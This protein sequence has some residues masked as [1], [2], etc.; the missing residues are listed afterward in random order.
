MIRVG[1]IGES[2]NDTMP[3]CEI[4]NREFGDKA[5]FKALLK[6]LTGGTLDS[7]PAASKRIKAELKSSVGKNKYD[8]LI[9]V[10][11][12]DG[13]ESE[14]NKVDNVNVWYNKL[15]VLISNHV[16][17]LNIHT[18]EALV[19]ADI[20]VFNKSYGTK[21][22]FKGDPQ[23][24]EKP[25]EFLKEKSRKT[26]RK[27]RERDIGELLPKLDFS[28]MKSKCSSFNKFIDELTEKLD[29]IIETSK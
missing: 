10:R 19:L 24:K 1:I 16:L 4:L 15:S 26:N 29:E 2:P 20:E 7:I 23:K 11:D 5:S 17:L 12:L 21:I 6:R 28:K 18:V 8:L 13:F 25:K 9:F 3:V 22:S 27:Y 14:K